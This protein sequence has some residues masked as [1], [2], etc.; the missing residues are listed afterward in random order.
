MARTI[1]RRRAQHLYPRILWER[2][3]NERF[4]FRIQPVDASSSTGRRKLARFHSDAWHGSW[5]GD[6]PRS[7]R[8][9]S[10]TRFKTINDR[11][12]RRWLND[13]DFEPV[14]Q[15]WHMRDAKWTWW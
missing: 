5:I 6:M 10:D 12:F 2:V 13:P 15:P 4:D 3:T 11:M 8:K 14:F 7:Y 1:R 9:A